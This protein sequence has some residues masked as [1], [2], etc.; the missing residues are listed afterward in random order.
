MTN[1]PA[2]R[3]TAQEL[4]P[5]ARLEAMTKAKQAKMLSLTLEL[6]KQKRAQNLRLTLAEEELLAE[7][8]R[9]YY[10][11]Y[12]ES[13]LVDSNGRV[14]VR[15]QLDAEP[16]MNTMKAYGDILGVKRRNDKMAGASLIGGIDPLTAGNWAKE[17]GLKVGTKEFAQ[18]AKK[19]IQNDS[20]YRKFRV[21]H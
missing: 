3:P 10:S 9:R 5:I 17:T 13:T 4:S 21:G 2:K 15:K 19:R 6:I 11:K 1:L 14:I 12:T 18:F 16:I 8:R 7:C 20:E